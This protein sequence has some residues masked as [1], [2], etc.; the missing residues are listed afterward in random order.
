MYYLVFVTSQQ[1]EAAKYDLVQLTNFLRTFQHRAVVCQEL[2][3]QDYGD[4]IS[5]FTKYPALMGERHMETS[6]KVVWLW[7]LY[8]SATH[9]LCDCGQMT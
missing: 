6:Q 5:A 4:H 8:P 9:W 7:F 1:R 2:G 3:D